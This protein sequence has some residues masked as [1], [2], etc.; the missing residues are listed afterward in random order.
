[1]SYDPDEDDAVVA[2]FLFAFLFVVVPILGVIYSEL[3][4]K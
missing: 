3:Y 1:M 2:I 4:F